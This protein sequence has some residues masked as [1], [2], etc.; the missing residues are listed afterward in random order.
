M[1]PGRIAIVACLALNAV[2]LTA[3]AAR[4]GG[5]PHAGVRIA[6]GHFHAGHIGVRGTV[7]IGAPFVGGYY[8]PS[9]YYPAPVPV[10]YAA[11]PAP[12]ATAYW[13]Y[14]APLGGYYPYVPNCPVPWQLVPTTPYTY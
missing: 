10:Y 6:P 3:H 13:H 2:A 14:C 5:A 9:Y 8:W 4:I 11:P 1:K 12:P 7:F